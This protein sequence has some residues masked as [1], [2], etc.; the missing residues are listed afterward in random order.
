MARSTLEPVDDVDF[1]VEQEQEDIDQENDSEQIGEADALATSGYVQVDGFKDPSGGT[2]IEGASTAVAIADL[3]QEANQSNSNSQDLS[4]TLSFTASRV[5][6]LGDEAD[7]EDV[8][9]WLKQEQEDVDQ[10]NDCDQYGVALSI[11]YADYVDV[12]LNGDLEAG[13]HRRR[14]RSPRRW[15]LPG[16]IK[17]LPP[18]SSLANLRLARAHSNSQDLNASTL[19]FSAASP[20]ADIDDVD[21][22]LKQEQEDIDQKNENEQYGEASAYATSEHVKVESDGT[23]VAGDFVG[24]TGDGIDAESEAV[25]VADL[26]QTA[27][28]SNDNSQSLTT[29]L[30]FTATAEIDDT[31]V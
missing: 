31:D 30:T 27:D 12:D 20:S 26:D 18:I 16:S 24:G 21:V 10:K 4:A 25:A 1:E 7:V 11:A 14:R 28:Q 22:R 2:G 3:A 23:I 13:G 8:D 29:N 6:V 15:R 17:R 19:S 5:N 9:V